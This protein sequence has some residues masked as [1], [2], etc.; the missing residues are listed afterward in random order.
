MTFGISLQIFNFIY[1]GHPSSIWVEWLPQ[2]LFMMCLF[3]YLSVMI[4]L[5]WAFMWNDDAGSA[6]GLLNTL[7]FMFLNP[8]TIQEDSRFFP[9]QVRGIL[10]SAHHMLISN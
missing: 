1:F 5:K 7:I 3:G 9:G 4:L 6:P 10:V 8:G 2:V